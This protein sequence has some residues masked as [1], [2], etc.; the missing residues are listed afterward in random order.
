M[1]YSTVMLLFTELR[2]AIFDLD[3]TLLDNGPVDRPELWLHSRSR[4]AAVHEVAQ[5]RGIEALRSLTDAEN[6][7]AFVTAPV[8]SLEGSIWNILFMKGMV[9]ANEIDTSDPH[10][11]LVTEI[12]KRKNE[13]HEVIIQEY[14]VEIPGASDF[15]KRL[16]ANGLADRLALATSVIRRDVNIFLDKY[17]LHDYFPPER[18]VSYEQVTKPK[19]D[20][21]C[22]EMAFQTLGLPDEARPFVAGFEDNPRGI[23]SVN[24]AHLFSCAITTRL[25]KDDPALLA[26]QPAIIAETYDEFA[27]VLG[28]PEVTD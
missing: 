23:S 6:G 21:Q 10:F 13:L 1:L 24:G 27:H 26:V 14:G 3:D 7:R 8:H 12:A 20:P 28:V 22:F 11:A 25:A 17:E 4:L 19:P 15:I 18:I 9:S 2:G 5:K 16:A